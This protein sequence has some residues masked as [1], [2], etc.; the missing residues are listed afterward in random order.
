MV[1][2]I[3]DLSYLEVETMDIIKIYEMFPNEDDC[4]HYLE[5]V[6]W[7]DKPKCPYCQSSSVTS[8]PKEKRHHCNTCNTSFSVTVRTIFHHTHLP[9]QKWF[10]AICI[11]LNAKKGI[12]ARQLSRD[13]HVNKDTAW[14]MDMKIR[15]AM[16]EREQRELL[17]GLVECD[18]TYIGGK[19]RP[20]SGEQHKRGRGTKKTPIL[21][22]AE[23]GGN[24]RAEVVKNRK[25]DSKNLKMLV[26]RN[27]DIKNATL[28]TDEWKGYIGIQM[29]MPHKIVD[30]AIWYVNGD[31]HTNTVE[32]FW[33]L[34]KRGIIGQYHKVS[35]RYLPKYVDEFSYRWNHRED[36]NLWATTLQRAV[37]A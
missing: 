32:S 21:G 9:L 6:R 3:I 23:R 10:L 29:I 4:I 17:T 13:L 20:G 8:L 5:T 7:K 2:T 12:A 11:A 18:E 28:I 22:M 37:E 36:T 30:H 14:R 35:L 31:A 25:L 24:F 1:S 19:L 15:Q 26:R 27:V 34:L 33:A 16:S